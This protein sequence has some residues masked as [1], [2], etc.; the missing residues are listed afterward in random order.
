M[1]ESGNPAGSF[2]ELRARSKEMGNRTEEKP[3]NSKKLQ[4]AEPRKRK[5]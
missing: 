3:P 5:K 1:L 4:K 2:E